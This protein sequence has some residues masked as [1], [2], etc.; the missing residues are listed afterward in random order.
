MEGNRPAG[1][2]VGVFEDDDFMNRSA[3]L[4]GSRLNVDTHVV[5]Q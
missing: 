3:V 2:G 4:F 5:H 1:G